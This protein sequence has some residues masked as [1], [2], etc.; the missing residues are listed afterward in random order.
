MGDG[1]ARDETGGGRRRCQVVGRLIL[2]GERDDD[3]DI[4][5]RRS[6]A[7]RDGGAGGLAGSATTH[8]EFVEHP[9]RAKRKISVLAFARREVRRVF[10]EAI[11]ER[12]YS[13]V[14]LSPLEDISRRGERW[15]R[16]GATGR[17]HRIATS[18]S[19]KYVS[20]LAAH[21]TNRDVHVYGRLSF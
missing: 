9:R 18:N 12:R 5:R 4:L 7:E 16:R 14:M 8:R 21:L 3:D 2:L 15:A 6:G 11:D 13:V 10:L 20:I 17:R 19:E 1:E